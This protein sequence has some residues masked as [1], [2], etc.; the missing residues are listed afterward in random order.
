MRYSFG[1]TPVEVISKALTEN[2]P[3]SLVGEDAKVVE[4]AVEMGIDS[5]LEAFTES[6]FRW[7]A[8]RLEC[9]VSPKDMLILLRRISEFGTSQA[10]DLRTAILSTLDIEEV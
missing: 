3:M 1:C 9:E 6:S 2:Y 4:Q 10:D 8:G 5:H 7:K